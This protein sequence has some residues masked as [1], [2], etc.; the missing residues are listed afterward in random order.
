LALGSLQQQG[1]RMHQLISSRSIVAS[2]VAASWLLPP[3]AAAQE[4]L[5]RPHLDVIYVPT[6]N[7]VVQRMLE[8]AQVR[9][10][11]YVIDLGSGDGRVLVAAAKTHGARGF[12]VD[13][14]PERVKEA[15]QN[16][17]TAGVADRVEFRQQNLFETPIREATVLTMYLMPDVNL[18]LRPRV[19]SE[20]RPGTRVVSH[21]FDMKDWKPDQRTSV[22]RSKVYMWIVP[23]KVEGRWTVQTDD[24][25]SLALDLK[26]RYQE[27]EGTATL[28]GRALPIRQGRVRGA[29]ISFAIATGQGRAIHY[30]GQIVGNMIQATRVRSP[31]SN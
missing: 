8:M 4:V 12:G 3:L 1:W 19:L 26:Q 15:R 27:I 18:K 31:R 11:D 17:Q 30:T 21:D 14:D 23:A 28:D 20:L 10:D 5:N 9:S 25:Q 13:I 6:P 24:G 2:L 7:N 29:Q 16:A 22:G